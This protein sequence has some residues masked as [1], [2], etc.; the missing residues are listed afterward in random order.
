[1]KKT[2]AVGVSGGVDSAVCA[3][4]LL[5]RGF[6]VTGV[7]LDVGGDS[8]RA[9]EV[10]AALDIPFVIVNARAELERL[11]INPFV[12]SYLKCQT[13]NPCVIC[14]PMVKYP[15]LIKAADELGA[16]HVATGHYAGITVQ[17]GVYYLRKGH[18]QRDQSYMLYRLPQSVLSRCIYPIGAMP[19]SEVRKRAAALNL[20]VADAPDSMEICFIPDDDYAAYIRS[21]GGEMPCGDIVD[22][23]GNVLGQHKGL[24]NYTVGQRRGLGVSS[25]GRLFVTSLDAEKNQVVLGDNTQLYKQKIKLRD[26]IWCGDDAPEYEILDIKLRHSRVAYKASVRGDTVH[27]TER[28]KAAATPGQSAVFYRD[29]IVLGG[30]I[31]C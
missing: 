14:N 9:E 10:C 8:T 29:D 12:E 28:V 17:D 11:V 21:R 27:F 25:G 13:P 26:I 2:V 7:F 4:I 23:N 31:I 3:A 19:K 5:E 30:G 15:M 6:N 16:E 18:P 1:M 24:Y 20:S 22:T